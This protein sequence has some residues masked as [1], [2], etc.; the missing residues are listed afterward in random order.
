MVTLKG[1]DADH[2]LDLENRAEKLDLPTYLTTDRG[3]TEIPDGSTTV[4]ALFGQESAVNS[5]T[6]DLEL[7]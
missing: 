7:L 3:L 4:L 2:L 6:G 1:T 5:I